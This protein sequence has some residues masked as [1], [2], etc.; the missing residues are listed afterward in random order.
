MRRPLNPAPPLFE[1]YRTAQWL[2]QFPALTLMVFLRRDLGYRLLN[3]LALVATFGLLFVLAVLSSPDNGA[4][5][6]MDL[7][8]FAVVGF[9][10]SM[11][12]RIRRWWT[13]NRSARQHSYY[14]GTSHFD[15]K[16]V[17]DIF[18]SNRRAARFLDPIACAG[19]GI[20]LF[21]VS[22]ALATWLILSA[23][24]LRAYEFMIHERQHN[25]ELDLTDSL[26]ESESQAEMLESGLHPQDSSIETHGKAIPTGIG[27]DIR[28]KI[29][30][31][32][33]SNAPSN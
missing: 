3:P 11:A 10:I 27:D 33:S 22:R 32:N 14:I 17:P 30:S 21:N 24:C 16:W 13:M 19:I 29:K 20:A 4:N 31:P 12:L 5:R 9:T 15:H 26:I 7:A 6:P 23:L 8:V 1:Q 2:M 25:V 28:H 18:R